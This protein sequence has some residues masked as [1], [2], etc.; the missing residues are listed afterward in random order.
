MKGEALEMAIAPSLLA[1]TFHCLG[2]GKIV[3]NK[4]IGTAFIL[5]TIT[6]IVLYTLSE[7]R[8]GKNPLVALGTILLII[9]LCSGF[10]Y[11]IM[12]YFMSSIRKGINFNFSISKN[13]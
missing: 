9:I 6:G 10:V 13:H 8:E 7:I 4:A 2:L 1:I 5:L 12:Y 3:T 11:I